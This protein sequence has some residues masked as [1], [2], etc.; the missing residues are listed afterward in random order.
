MDWTV[1]ERWGLKGWYFGVLILASLIYNF[2]NQKA[3]G[4]LGGSVSGATNF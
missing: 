3:G 1:T 2:R 4:R